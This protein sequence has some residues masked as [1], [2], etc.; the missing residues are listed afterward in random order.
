MEE[1]CSQ[2]S[3]STEVCEQ[4]QMGHLLGRRGQSVSTQT[5]V[6]RDTYVSMHPIA[7]GCAYVNICIR[8]HCLA[9]VHSQDSASIHTWI[10]AVRRHK[11]CLILTLTP[12]ASLY[13]AAEAESE[14]HLPQSD[15]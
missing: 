2:R 14:R 8:G 9:R 11:P 12:K 13:T 7:P 15:I 3:A 4:R 6:P 5:H 1:S 10:R